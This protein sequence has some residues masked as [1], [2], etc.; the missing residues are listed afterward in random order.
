MR[1]ITNSKGFY[2]YLYKPTIDK[3]HHKRLALPDLFSLASPVGLLSQYKIYICLTAFRAGSAPPAP[4]LRLPA[5]LRRRGARP[6]IC[7]VPSGCLGPTNYSINTTTHI[8][9]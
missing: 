9:Q 6:A 2:N 5:A 7:T 1:C 4:A 3:T 8:Q